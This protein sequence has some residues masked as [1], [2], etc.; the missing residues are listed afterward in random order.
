MRVCENCKEEI[1]PT[2]IQFAC[3][4][5]HFKQVL[6]YSSFRLMRLNF[7]EMANFKPETSVEAIG[8]FSK[9]SKPPKQIPT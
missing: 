7:H 2:A 5:V 6:V 1:Y 3:E 9:Q 4:V 8:Q